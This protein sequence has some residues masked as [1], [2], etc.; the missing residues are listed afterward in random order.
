MG[1]RNFELER[2]IEGAGTNGM[3]LMSGLERISG[4]ISDSGKM[5]IEFHI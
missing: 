5:L 4:C 1:K 2:K 3:I